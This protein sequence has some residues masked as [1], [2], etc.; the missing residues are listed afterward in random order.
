MQNRLQ[1]PVTLFK[2]AFDKE[3]KGVITLE[4][5]LNQMLDAE[6]PLVSLSERI[7]TLRRTDRPKYDDVKQRELPAF[8]IGRWSRAENSKCEQYVNLLGFDVD[9]L[10]AND[11]DPLLKELRICPYVFAA[12]PSPSGEGI[13]ALIWCDCDEGTHKQ[14][15][16]SAAQ[17]LG[18]FLSIETDRAIEARGKAQGLQPD[19]VKLLVKQTRH[20]D[21]ATNNTAR[22]WFYSHVPTDQLFLNPESEVFTLKLEDLKESLPEDTKRTLTEEDRIEVCRQK[23]SRQTLPIGRNHFVYAFAA[24][25]VQHGVSEARAISECGSYEESDFSEAEIKKTVS[26]AYRQKT[27]RY[28]DAQILSYLKK[29]NGGAGAPTGSKAPPQASEPVAMEEDEAAHLNKRQKLEAALQRHYEFRR[30]N[31]TKIPEFRLKESNPEFK[32]GST[33][34]R[35]TDDDLFSVERKLQLAGYSYAS[36]VTIRKIISS[37]FSPSYHPIKAFF[38]GLPEYDGEDHIAALAATIKTIQGE[39]LYA[40]YLKK[41]LTGVVANALIEKYCANHLCLILIGQQGDNK[42]KW[43]SNLYPST[44]L[45]YCKNGGMDPDEKD[46]LIAASENLIINMDDYFAD[47]SAKKVNSLKGFITLDVIKIR[48][49]YGRFDEVLPKI[50][51]FIGSTNESQFLYDDTGDRRFLCFEVESMDLAAATAID[52]DKVWAQAKHL[53]ETGFVYWVPKEEAGEQQRINE[54]YRVVSYELE[55]VERFFKQPLPPDVGEFY[56]TSSIANYLQGY[57]KANLSLKRIGQA[58][59]LLQIPRV[60]RRD[61]SK[62]PVW[63]YYLETT[64][65]VPE[66][67]EALR[68]RT[69]AVPVGETTDLVHEDLP[70]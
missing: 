3:P 22:L 50:C 30:N 32:K 7:Q 33:W 67:E 31:L 16:L 46:S 58:M 18:N 5:L 1:T 70:F 15:Y 43:I 63:G 2:G 62:V 12:F 9:A 45:D 61:A 35:M 6:S 23:V 17:Y 44:L 8:I 54:T 39:E 40:K 42:S 55:M 64:A 47:I 57:T 52:M 28:S 66:H 65:S 56:T 4:E 41:W 10:P 13:R 38:N 11:V 60:S 14:T 24:E 19:G 49:P 37:D 27:N 53:F 68:R 69:E 25:M 36:E 26:S 59:K 21:T 29:L 48:R 51:S 34:H 20:I